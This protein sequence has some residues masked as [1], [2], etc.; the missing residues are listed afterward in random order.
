MSFFQPYL[1]YNYFLIILHFL[2][3]HRLLYQATRFSDFSA[4]SKGTK[5]WRAV[6]V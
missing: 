4:V 5:S 3:F 2:N 1:N 6:F